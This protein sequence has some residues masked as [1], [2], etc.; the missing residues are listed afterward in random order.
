M[1]QAEVDFSKHLQEWD[2][3]GAGY[4]ETAR[5]AEKI[6]TASGGLLEVG[7]EFVD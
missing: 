1:I 4:A 7:L 2:G 3:F 6:V 5:T